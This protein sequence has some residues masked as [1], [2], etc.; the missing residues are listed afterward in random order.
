MFEIVKFG[1][2]ILNNAF[3]RQKL[4]IMKLT[5]N[6]TDDAILAELGRRLARRRI[7]R[8]LTQAE[9]ARQAGVSK[10]TLERI[11]AGGSSQASNLIRV[12]RVLDLV[13]ALEG[14]IP[15]PTARPMELLGHRRKK[16]VRAPSPQGRKKGSEKVPS[17][18]WGDEQ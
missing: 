14:A 18:T 7:E 13:D 11:E 3:V 8:E 6:L 1:D 5:K 2:I 4:R 12:L 17:W 16:R 9:L 10:R 15:E